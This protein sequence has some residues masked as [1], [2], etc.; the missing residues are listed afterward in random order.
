MPIPA[1]RGG[2]SENGVYY[3]GCGIVYR[4]HL[5]DQSVKRMSGNEHII[6]KTGIV[7]EQ[8][9]ACYPNLVRRFGIFT[10]PHQPI[11]TDCEGGCGKKEQKLIENQKLFEYS[12]IEEIVDVIPIGIP[13]H[14]I[15]VYRLKK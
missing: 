11:F 6:G 1:R 4:N 3:K 13:E 7:Y 10:F 14:N 2:F 8:Y 5:S 15:Y 12:A 9:L